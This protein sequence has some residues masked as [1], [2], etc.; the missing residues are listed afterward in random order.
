MRSNR[1]SRAV[2]PRRRST[3]SIPSIRCGWSSDSQKTA[4]NLPEHGSEP[5]STWASSPQGASGSSTQSHWISAPGGCSI[6]I[7][8]LALH[9]VARLAVRAQT[10]RSQL[11]CEGLVAAREAERVHLV[12]QCR[13]PQV[14]VL[15]EA[16][17]DVGHERREGVGPGSTSLADGRR[18]SRYLRIVLRSRSRCRAIAEIDQPCF[19]NAVASMS[20][21]PVNM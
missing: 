7:V 15:A 18:R 12:E 2:P 19:L 5:T 21:S 6:S 10:P 14:R 9:P 13:R 16:L 11:S 8:A 1:H 17:C 4:R 3:S 20:S